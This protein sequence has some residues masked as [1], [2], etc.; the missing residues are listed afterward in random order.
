[1][2]PKC[3]K[4]LSIEEAAQHLDLW[5]HLRRNLPFEELDRGN[6]EELISKAKETLIEDSK[7]EISSEI[8]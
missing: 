2:R 4:A 7:L 1:L 3:R 6:A 5:L 8:Q